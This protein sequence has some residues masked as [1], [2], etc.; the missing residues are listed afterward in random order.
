MVKR[1]IS[2]L[3]W[4][5]LP[6]AAFG[7]V[8]NTT[9]SVSFTCTGSAGPFPFTFPI[10]DPTAMTVTQS[11]TVIPSSGYII[12]PVNNNYANGGSVTLNVA[13]PNAGILVLAR[14]TPLTQQSAFYESMPAPMATTGSSLDKLTEIVQ[15]QQNAF[16]SGLVTKI[17]AGSGVTVSPSGGTGQVTVSSFIGGGITQLAGDVH[18]GPGTG[19]VAAIVTGLETVPFCTGFAPINGQAIQYTTGS[20][21]NP[22]YTA[23]SSSG[24]GDTIT[25]PNST[26]TVGGTTTNTTV[27]VNTAHANTWSAAQGFPTGST[28]VTQSPGDNTTK[29][30]TD[31]F[32][33]ANAGS[34]GTPAGATGSVQY[35]NLGAFG[36]TNALAYPFTAKILGGDYEASANGNGTT[37]GIASAA[38]S[39]G[40]GALIIAD[41]GYPTTEQPSAT[42]F[43]ANQNY[44]DYRNN[45]MLRFYHNPNGPLAPWYANQPWQQNGAETYI[46]NYDGLGF[47]SGAGTG[48][49]YY[50]AGVHN[51][52]LKST[53]PGWNCGNNNISG[54]CEGW[55]DIGVQSLYLHSNT[56]GISEV[57][58]VDNEKTGTGDNVAVYP[59][60]NNS[61]NGF[62]APSDEG[63]GTIFGGLYEDQYRYTGTITSGGSAGST[64]L[65]TTAITDATYQGV[66][67]YV[68]DASNTPCTGKITNIANNYNGSL[69]TV[70]GVSGCTITA[71]SFVG[72]LNS[73]VQVPL[74]STTAPFST[75]VTFATT[76]VSGTAAGSSTVPYCFDGGY[77]EQALAT[78]ATTVG[79]TVTITMLLRKPHPAG[80]R[81][82]QGGACGM[83]L[84]ATAFTE[85]PNGQA[86]RYL[87]D[88]VGSSDSTHLQTVVWVQGSAHN[89][90]IPANTYQTFDVSSGVT[91]GGSGTT[92][93]FTIPGSGALYHPFGYNKS[94]IVFAGLSD[95]AL[96]TTCTN[97]VWSSQSAGTCTIAGLSG[98]H[99]DT[100]GGTA[101]LGI[102]GFKLMPIA[103]T[104]S[105]EN[106][107]TS[108]PS[109]D[110][111]FIL[112]PNAIQWAN[113]HTLEQTHHESASDNISSLH[114]T[115]YNPYAYNNGIGVTL[116]GT[117]ATGG[118][119]SPSSNAVFKGANLNNDSIY[120]GNG[121][122]LGPANA[123]NFT[124]PYA[125]G[126]AFDHGPMTNQSFINIFASSTQANDVNY[127]YYL[128]QSYNLS[129]ADSYNICPNS[130]NSNLTVTGQATY[131][132]GVGHKFNGVVNLLSGLQANGNAIVPSNATLP[133]VGAK[134]YAGTGAPSDTCSSS[135]NT[136]AIEINAT[137]TA[138]QCSNA[139]GSYAWNASAGGLPTLAANSVL[140]TN[141]TP[142]ASFSTT[143]PSGLSFSTMYGSTIY[144]AASGDANASFSAVGNGTTYL[145]TQGTGTTQLGNA[146]GNVQIAGIASMP[147]GSKAQGTDATQIMFNASNYGAGDSCFGLMLGA[148][149]EAVFGWSQG[150][151]NAYI[152]PT[153]N[154]TPWAAFNAST[155]KMTGNINATTGYQ[156]NGNTVI[157][158][159]VTGDQG[160]GVKLQL[161]TGST[162]T[163]DCVKFDANGN[164][165]D[166]G[167]SCGTSSMVYPGAGVANS[168]GSAWGTSYTVGTGNNNLVQLN[169]SA[170][171]PA[172]SAA[173][174]TNFPTFNQNTT[175]YAAY[176]AGG[177]VG[178]IPYQTGANVTAFLAANTAAT[179]QVLVSH[180]TGAAGLAPTLTNAP[181]ISLA[182]ASSL[183]A[184]ALPSQY[185]IWTCETG[186]G[187]GYNAMAAQSYLQSMCKNTTGVTITLTGVQCY[188]DGGTTSTLNASGNTLGA[189]LT[190]AITCSTSF[191][192]GTQSAN[193][194]LTN[195]D[196]IKFTFAADGTAKQ[197]TWVV[198]GTY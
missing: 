81:V 197:T 4:I 140:V 189:L 43:T 185:K 77:H 38:S 110:G 16:A 6:C 34:G 29:I 98:S 26:I 84:E 25:S 15:E 32:V 148:T 137:P 45:S 160:N 163:N 147:S 118:G 117:A 18:A 97:A 104:L 85:T 60:T 87:I 132:A 74:N 129:G 56:S 103:E 13:C 187:D 164:T 113:S 8:V 142:T 134:T 109:V 144:G 80:T 127:C 130:G 111:T 53:T 181:A 41:P 177:T 55:Y 145:G 83:G 31:A 9:T 151:S 149:T 70:S 179:D 126:F 76:V 159:T 105:V 128:W 154:S 166:S 75:S 88:V 123:F 141:G 19:S 5:L 119:A 188:I 170:Q 174:L 112:E 116:N 44:I 100:T 59:T 36:G 167:G 82:W 175:G 133:Y 198:T 42:S 86:L 138:Y 64:S 73:D 168:T 183:P 51:L 57:I 114:S 143:L 124:G 196:Y 47:G 178:Q 122:Y 1:A 69:V 12:S 95:S 146:S 92:V 139:T 11:G 115:L 193:V 40:A 10:S 14:I 195:G 61:H 131:Y 99:T 20:S 91:N 94:S 93:S 46:T 35:N 79:S 65:K 72:T 102:S 63:T 153:C 67:Q 180:G 90:P 191:A 172:V 22:C 96:N 58:S 66:G 161:S 165:V 171:L 186:L 3:A 101:S 192:A 162:T 173:N 54:S 71:S 2:I 21:P 39:G 121:G 30:A 17:I 150:N 52:V 182:N 62:V 48:G 37:T 169:G 190:G 89:I 176:L 50:F 33:L 155:F 106:E 152:A 23:S 158:S 28:A 157:P 68:L 125:Y 135:T 184:S 136:F 78:G 107:S 120:V 108:P 156:V 7:T 24:S 27:D 194:A 49:T